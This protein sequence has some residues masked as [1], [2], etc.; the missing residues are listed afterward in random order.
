MLQSPC[1]TLGF[2]KNMVYEIPPGGRYTISCQWPTMLNTKPQGHWPFGS[3]EEDFC[4]HIHFL[5]PT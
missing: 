2:K 1:K 4:D 3:R 5:P